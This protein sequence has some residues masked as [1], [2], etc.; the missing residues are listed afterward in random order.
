MLKKKLKIIFAGSNEFS[1]AHLRSL[2]YSKHTIA[3]IIIKLDNI[4]CKK[5]ENRFSPIKKFAI[6]HNISIL[7]TNNLYEKKIYSS[8]LKIYADILIVS[9]YGSIIPDKIL[10]L[11]T[12]G[13]INIHASLLPRW[14]GAAPI[15]W[16]ILSGDKYTG[17]SVIKMNSKI[18]C[19]KII[20]QLSCPINITDNAITLS[21]KLIPISLQCMYQSLNIIAES[22]IKNL[23]KNK[24]VIE[25]IAP[26]IKK[27]DAKINW[28]YPVIKIDRL[29]RAFIIWPC[30]YFFINNYCIKIKKSSIIS[31]EKT[32]FKNGEIINISKE[33]IAVNT[34][35]G[36]LNIKKIQIPG[37]KTLHIKQIL[38]SNKKFFIKNTILK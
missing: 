21:A 20:Y 1:L 29:I 34:Q 8:I 36:V 2:F 9:S 37:K 33:G 19:G 27:I 24:N 30:C 11:F 35:K 5:K 18:D 31:F 3:A 38:N 10:Q 14:K 4:Y 17:I 6:R 26:K 16:A 32:N 25:T 23:H 7:Q 13:G 28:S 15:Q 22:N 12:F